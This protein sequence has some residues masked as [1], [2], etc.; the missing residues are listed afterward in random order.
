[1]CQNL[2]KL[3]VTFFLYEESRKARSLV[4]GGMPEEQAAE[5]VLGISYRKLGLG[6][7]RHWNFPARLLEGM[8]TLTP[9]DMVPPTTE[10]ENLRLA[11]NLAN[12]LYVTALCTPQE[13]KTAALEALSK[14]YSGAVKLDAQQLIEAIDQ[15]LKEV[16]ERSTTL[17]L[18]ASGSP[19]LNAVRVWTGGAAD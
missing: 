10:G 15:G 16:A 8:Q 9:R 7:A 19:T 17:N 2:G 14:R 18:S 11:A 5:Q 6:V 4:E 13:N 12:D 3:L 1:M